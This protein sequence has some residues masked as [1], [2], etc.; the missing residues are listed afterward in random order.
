M[1]RHS[2]TIDLDEPLLTV[3][4]VGALL[5]VSRTGV[6]RL[7]DRGDLM[8]IRVGGRI[9]FSPNDVRAYLARSRQQ[10]AS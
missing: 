4:E 7:I 1:L 3:S 5:R 6:Y 9:R 8:P 10:V 2:G